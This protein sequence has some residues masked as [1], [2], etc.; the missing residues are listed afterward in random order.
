M[1][2]HGFGPPVLL[3]GQQPAERLGENP[4]EEERDVEG[5][6][7]ASEDT[8]EEEERVLSEEGKKEEERRRGG[9]RGRDEGENNMGR[10]RALF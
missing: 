9:E 2:H 8:Q 3:G 1:Q 4:A 5:G 10:K 7:G 6:A